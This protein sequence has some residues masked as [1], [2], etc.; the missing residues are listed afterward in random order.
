ML[1]Q[2]VFQKTLETTKKLL[3]KICLSNNQTIFSVSKKVKNE[4]K[5]FVEHNHNIDYKLFQV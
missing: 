1:F 5:C 2:L 4:L 3:K